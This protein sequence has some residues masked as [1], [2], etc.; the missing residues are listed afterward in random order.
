MWAHVGLGFAWSQCET[1]AKWL[2]GNWQ[3]AS[4]VTEQLEGSWAFCGYFS[5]ITDHHRPCSLLEAG[6][7]Q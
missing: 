3:E 5:W 7:A 2:S 1:F 6:R 4:K